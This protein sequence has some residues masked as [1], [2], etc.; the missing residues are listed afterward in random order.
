MS[1]DTYVV[2][3]WNEGARQQER[4]ILTAEQEFTFDAL[5]FVTLP[6]VLCPDELSACRQSAGSD[7]EALGEL[8]SDGGALGRYLREL[9]GDGFRQDG[10]ATHVPAGAAMEQAEASLPLDGGVDTLDRA[11][12][13]LSGWNGRNADG[14]SLSRAGGAWEEIRI[15]QC[16]GLF[17]VIALTDSPPGSCPVGSP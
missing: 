1:K 8:C 2:R 12:I 4:S 6:Q 5:G 11:Y 16:Q 17:A 7:S 13:N 3:H 14:A 15:R 10:H 9:C